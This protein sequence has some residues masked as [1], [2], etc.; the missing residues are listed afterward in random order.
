MLRI[1]RPTG[2]LPE[3]FW[4]GAHGG[5]GE[6]VLT[7]ATQ[8]TAGT[9]HRWPSPDPTGPRARAVLLART[10]AAGLA[11]AKAALKEWNE[12]GAGHCDLLGLLLLADAPGRYPKELKYELAMT[13]GAAPRKPRSNNPQVWELDWIPEWRTRQPLEPPAMPTEV[14]RVLGDILSA[15]RPTR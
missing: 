15:A 6:T 11:I 9:D 14:R 8:N 7:A 13:K 2:P 12:G 10:H 3:L 1:W 5:A 4:I